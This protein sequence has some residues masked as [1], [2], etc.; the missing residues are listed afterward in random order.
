MSELLTGSTIGLKHMK[1]IREQTIEKWNHLGFLEG[2]S[3]HVK[4]NIAQ[5]YEC[6]ACSL[7]N[8]VSQTGD[9]KPMP[10]VKKVFDQMDGT[11]IWGTETTKRFIPI[12]KKR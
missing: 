5:L 1:A 6:Q 7:L 12:F 11:P 9:T 8:E 4:E 10:I 3:G 2:I